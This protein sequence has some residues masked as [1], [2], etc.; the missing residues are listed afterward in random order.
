MKNAFLRESIRKSKEL[1][2]LLMKFKSEPS[3]EKSKVDA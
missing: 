3:K 1:K 2:L